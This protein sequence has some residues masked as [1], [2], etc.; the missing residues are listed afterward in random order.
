M[1]IPTRCAL[2]ALLPFMLTAACAGGPTPS[3]TEREGSQSQPVNSRVEASEADG[4][5]G[6]DEAMEEAELTEKRLEAFKS[7]LERGVVGAGHTIRNDPARGWFGER[8]LNANTDDWEPAVAADPKAPYVYMLTTRFGEPRICHQHCPTPFL[9][10][11]VS[12]NG[13]KTWG[14]QEPVCVCWGADALYDPT[15]EVVPNT[16]VV[17]SVFLNIDPAGG[18]STAFVKSRD[19]G[20]TWTKPVPVQGQVAWTDKP[21]ITSSA[22]GRDVYV[23]WNGPR[24]GDLY[25]GI[26]HDFGRTWSQVKLSD[27]KRYFY[28]YDGTVLPDGTV[29]FSE[30][31]LAYTGSDQSVRGRIW[32][33]AVIS[34]DRGHTWHQVVIDKV[35]EGVSCVAAGCSDDFYL[36]QTSV[37]SDSNG[38]LV[39]A[40]E[41]ARSAGGPQRVYVRTS[42]D[43]GRTWSGPIALSVMGENATQPRVDFA[44]PGQARIWYM[45]TSGGGDPNAW[46]VEFRSSPDAGRTWSPAV[47][48]SDATSGPGY[49]TAKGFK[50]IYGDYGEI[51]VTNRGKVIAV[52]GEGFSYIGP[53]GTWFALQK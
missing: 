37:A 51:A 26:S 19:H 49:V 29:V 12:S 24:G 11:T 10:L 43:Q 15:I 20:R 17:Y 28:A 5:T 27:S 16:G 8:L 35:A 44:G 46:R 36:G 42:D 32:H 25:V 6:N 9:A 52:W 13:G 21:E 23:S 30:S 47:R 48:L 50:E 33:Y 40:Y 31:S 18:W 14:P 53:G 2:A 39:F 3:S 22:N 4:R 7:A 45:Q 34:R 1:N 41:G 38:Q